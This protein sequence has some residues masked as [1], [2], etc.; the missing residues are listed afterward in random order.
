MPVGGEEAG[1]LFLE[2]GLVE[3]GGRPLRGEAEHGLG[4]EGDV[5]LP[6]REQQQ[7]QRLPQPRIDFAHH[8]QVEEVDRVVPPHQVPGVRV[9]VEEPVGED[10]LVVGLE[11][12]P[13]R[14]AA[15]LARWC[16]QQRDPLNLLQDQQPPGG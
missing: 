12:L 15:R 9:G 5:F 8:P 6:E 3:V 13:G 14:L 11:Q 16:L 1:Q 4:E 2:C 7:Q 10:L